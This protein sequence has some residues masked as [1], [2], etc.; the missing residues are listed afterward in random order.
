MPSNYVSPEN[1]SGVSYAIS[2][3]R[4]S[5]QREP[6]K[7]DCR[8][9][10]K[11][12]EKLK[13]PF[14]NLIEAKDVAITCVETKPFRSAS[15]YETT[16]PKTANLRKDNLVDKVTN[17]E[18]INTSKGTKGSRLFSYTDRQT[19][20]RDEDRLEK[21]VREDSSYLYYF[22][23]TQSQSQFYKQLEE[24][25]CWKRVEEDIFSNP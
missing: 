10:L 19:Y 4:I 2:K 15:V 12:T 5:K 11:I 16:I 23:R 17:I 7:R 6:P 22:R 13:K 21:T 18:L 24:E 9:E 14:G 20:P 8:A 25:T 3:V 1:I